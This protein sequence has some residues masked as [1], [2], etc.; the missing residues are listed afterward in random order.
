MKMEALQAIVQKF[1]G[2]WDYCEKLYANKLDNQEEKE[3]FLETCNL[4]RLSQE[5]IDLTRPMTSEEIESV[6]EIFQ[7]TNKQT[8]KKT[9]QDQMASLVNFAKHFRN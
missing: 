4:P 9:P 5:E 2:W 6:T 7:K 1:K 8:N 3:K